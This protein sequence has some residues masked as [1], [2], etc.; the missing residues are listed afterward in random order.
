[1]KKIWFLVS[2]LAC[3]LLLTWCQN[4]NNL[5]TY[6][7]KTAWCEKWI[8]S[9]W[10]EKA[11]FERKWIE[12]V[13]DKTVITW[14]QYGYDWLANQE[15]SCEFN[16]N[17]KL[18]WIKSSNLRNYETNNSW[19]VINMWENIIP[20]W[21]HYRNLDLDNEEDKAEY[22][23]LQ[24]DRNMILKYQTDTSAAVN[25]FIDII[26]DDLLDYCQ[27]YWTNYETMK[28]TMYER[29]VC[30]D[31][32]IKDLY[33]KLR[34]NL[35]LPQKDYSWDDP[36]LISYYNDL[37]WDH[38][39]VRYFVDLYDILKNQSYSIAWMMPKRPNWPI[40]SED[41]E[42]ENI[43]DWEAL[44]DVFLKN[45]TWFYTY[46]QWNIWKSDNDESY[47]SWFWSWIVINWNLLERIQNE[48]WYNF[49]LGV[50]D[51]LYWTAPDRWGVVIHYN[52]WYNDYIYQI[53]REWGGSWEFY[54]LV[55]L[56]KDWLR[57]PIWN[58]WY[59]LYPRYP[60]LFW[61]C[62]EWQ[63]FDSLTVLTRGDNLYQYNNVQWMADNFRYFL[64]YLESIRVLSK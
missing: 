19:N 38:P 1:M 49:P 54:L 33:E 36:V 13:W 2:F 58:C 20:W 27:E 48:Y 41:S 56:L 51:I 3:S 35:I 12:K 60:V 21:Y 30:V 31:N 44:E 59:L 45:G 53:Y 62:K 23:A 50:D 25:K 61:E 55:W 43:A 63:N 15:V 39:F 64:R 14:I 17:G 16:E 11:D 5:T 40:L 34:V 42:D 46:S 37:N 18:L 26:H 29:D 47:I 57:I 8:L 4:Y 28:W 24:N 32:Y 6:D 52:D 22:V 10:V 9:H 7:E